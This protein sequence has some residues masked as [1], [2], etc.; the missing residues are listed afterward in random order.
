MAFSGSVV[1]APYMRLLALTAVLPALPLLSQGTTDHLSEKMYVIRISPICAD[2]E[3]LENVVAPQVKKTLGESYGLLDHVS[4]F[5][6]PV[7][8]KMEPGWFLVY[9]DPARQS[10]EDLMQD[11]Y[12]L[13]WALHGHDVQIHPLEQV[14]SPAGIADLKAPPTRKD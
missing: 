2:A 6:H 10:Q 11:H 12:L 4:P 1:R 9:F 14:A 5:L 8:S 3:Q 7:M 13:D